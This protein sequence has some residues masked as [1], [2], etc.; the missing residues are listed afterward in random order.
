MTDAPQGGAVLR[1][2]HL[3]TPF[4][5]NEIRRGCPPLRV[6]RLL[7]SEAG[8]PAHVRVSRFEDCDEDGATTIGWRETLDGDLIDGPDRRR[9]GWSE[10]QAHASFPAATTV[11][12]RCRIETPVGTLDCRRYTVRGPE[13]TSTYWFADAKPGMPVRFEHSQT[14]GVRIEVEMIDDRVG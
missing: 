2:D 13:R 4:T 14:D 11:V 8:T 12:D 7:V 5:A 10:L 1:P 3:P 6:T 9:V